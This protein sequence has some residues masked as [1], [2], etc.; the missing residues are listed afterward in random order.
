[1]EK[2]DIPFLTEAFL[3]GNETLT[4]T[5][6][7]MLYKK[8]EHVFDKIDFEDQ[9]IYQEPLIFAFLNDHE[10]DYNIDWLLLGY[11]KKNVDQAVSVQSD[12]FGRIYLANIGWLITGDKRAEFSLRRNSAQ[13]LSLFKNDEEVPFT[14]EPL[15]QS[16]DGK[17]ELVNHNIPL[18]RKCFYDTD[19]SLLQVE[20][21]EIAALRQ[22]D[23]FRA[24]DLMKKY[25][26]E[27]YNLVT[28]AT[29]KIQVFNVDTYKSNS[30]ATIGAQGL[31]FFNAYQEDYDE[32]FFLDDI[33][34]QTGHIIMN[35][36]LFN[37][38]DYFKVD[39]ATIL[40]NVYAENGDLY[41]TRDVEVLIHALYTYYSTFLTL[42]TFLDQQVFEGRK[43]HELL[44]RM[45][46]YLE[47]CYSDLS[48]FEQPTF[49]FNK[50]EKLYKPEDL[51]TENGLTIYNGIKHYFGEMFNKWNRI[52]KS[53]DLGNQP[54]NF[55]YSKFIELN[56]YEL[57]PVE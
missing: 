11:M 26:P 56:P 24:I 1:M 51:F 9:A 35:G 23:L 43:R 19:G 25:M 57:N 42:N 20:I 21:D 22:H 44:A 27:Y 13:E 34:H 38:E 48:L 33:A 18:L 17:L 40:Q 32:I 30:F 37:K 46:F 8:D 31:A 28:L 15:L 16:A 36:I 4:N 49:D 55:T 29:K 3:M 53:Y 50:T 39:P 7:T 6:K 10:I 14:L 52:T 54:Y 47:K 41:E 5:I 12:D 45:A 2:F